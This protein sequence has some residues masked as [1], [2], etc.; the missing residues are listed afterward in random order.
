MD[1]RRSQEARFAPL[2]PAKPGIQR[3]DNPPSLSGK[4]WVLAPAGA[5]GRASV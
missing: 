1:V 4:D 3:Q 2:I 5:S